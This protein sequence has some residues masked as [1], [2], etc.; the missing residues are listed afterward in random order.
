ML[1]WHID[2]KEKLTSLAIIGSLLMDKNSMKEIIIRIY[3]ITAAG[4][5]SRFLKKGIKPPKPLI[6]VFGNELLIWSMNSFDFQSEDN[7]YIVTYKHH[8][9]KEKIE[10]NQKD[11]SRY[12][13]IM[14]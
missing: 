5:G 1:P 14:A 8:H 10:K 2:N 6:K 9:V 3:L 13:Y 12:I 4:K 7:I 11:L